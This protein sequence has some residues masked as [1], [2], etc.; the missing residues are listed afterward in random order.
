VCAQSDEIAC[1]VL[2][3]IREAGLACPGDLA[4]IGVDA[5]PL[6][7]ISSPPLT[8]VEFNPVAVADAAIAA[9]LT[10]LGYQAPPAPQPTD[11]V[12]L[13]VRAST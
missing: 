7:A 10:E 13:I 8:T 1:L 2:Y 6:G 5:N 11:I 4:V 9:V 12:R 3:G